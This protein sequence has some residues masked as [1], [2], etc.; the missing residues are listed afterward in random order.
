VT[1]PLAW[2]LDWGPLT[3]LLFTGGVLLFAPAA[4]AACS[5]ADRARTVACP[6]PAALLPDPL[7]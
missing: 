3:G 2:S 4:G 5:R 7:R 6:Q 1:I